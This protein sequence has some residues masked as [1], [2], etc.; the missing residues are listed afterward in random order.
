MLLDISPLCLYHNVPM[1]LAQEALHTLLHE[2]TYPWF[3][4]P[5]IGCKQ[6]YDMKRGYYVMREGTVEDETNKH[7]CPYCSLRVYLAKRSATFT[8]AVWLCA[9]D[10]C[11]SNRRKRVDLR[12]LSYE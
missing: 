3:D 6:R 8:D 5:V 7:P 4:C 10:Q 11:P 1:I 2:E 12:S 9:N